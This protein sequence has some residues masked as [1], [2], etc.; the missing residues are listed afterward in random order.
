LPHGWERHRVIQKDGRT[1]AVAPYAPDDDRFTF[2]QGRSPMTSAHRSTPP[3]SAYDAIY[4]CHL[5]YGNEDPRA[6]APLDHVIR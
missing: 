5:A 6:A 3:R 2:R 1:D 4:C